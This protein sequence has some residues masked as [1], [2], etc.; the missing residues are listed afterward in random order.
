MRWNMQFPVIGCLVRFFTQLDA[1]WRRTFPQRNNFPFLWLGWEFDW[2][3]DAV[4]YRRRR[5]IVF[6]CVHILR[7][8]FEGA[9]LLSSPPFWESKTVPYETQSSLVLAPPFIGAKAMKCHEAQ[10]PVLLKLASWREIVAE[11]KQAQSAGE[12]TRKIT[13]RQ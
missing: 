4:R 13:S 7:F 6:C 1:F 10:E 2:L 11:P 9:G 8:V 3:D 5:I 12:R